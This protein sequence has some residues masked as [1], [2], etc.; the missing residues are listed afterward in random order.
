MNAQKW[1]ND[2]TNSAWGRGIAELSNM[3]G[4]VLCRVALYGIQDEF[5]YFY[6]GTAYNGENAWLLVSPT[7][8]KY[9]NKDIY[10]AGNS[11]KLDVSWQAKYLNLPVLSSAPA[12]SEGVALYISDSG[13]GGETPALPAEWLNNYYTK[14]EID[15]TILPIEQQVT[16]NTNKIATLEAKVRALENQ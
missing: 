9:K 2:V 1:V 4:D 8:L 14:L 11:N 3:N 12:I 7:S 13:V 6:V 10:H 16:S 15:N 5:K